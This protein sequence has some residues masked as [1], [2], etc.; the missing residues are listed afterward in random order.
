MRSVALA[1]ILGHA[2]RGGHE[3][4]AV[5]LKQPTALAVLAGWAERIY[6]MDDITA[7]RLGELGHRDKVSVQYAVGPD[8][9]KTPT[10]PHLFGLLRDMVETDP[11]R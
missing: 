3:V 6:A 4:V 1:R 10:H 5:G 2:E 11:P 7:D 9:W 8:D